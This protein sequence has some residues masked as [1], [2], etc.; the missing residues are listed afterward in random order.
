MLKDSFE[1]YI[2]KLTYLF[3]TCLENG[4]FQATCGIGEISAIPK[5][6]INNNKN[7]KIGAQLLK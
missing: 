6:T 1:I 7:L 2:P 5:I 4:D 3:N